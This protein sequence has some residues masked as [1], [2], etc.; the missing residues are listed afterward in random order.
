MALTKARLSALVMMTT[1][2][3]FCIGAR[4][5][6]DGSGLLL[7]LAGTALV[8]SSAAVLNQVAE[9]ETDSL[10]ERTRNR[11]IPA[12]RIRVRT[13]LILGIVLGI[14]GFL[15]LSLAVNFEAALLGMASL[16]IYVLAYT[17]MKRR[18]ASC[19]FVGAIAGALPPVI[20]WVAAGRGLD[21]GA[22]ILFGILFLWQMPHFLAIAWMHRGEYARAG[23]VMLRRKDR[24]GVRAALNG[25]LFSLALF[26]WTTLPVPFGM[27]GPWYLVVAVLCSGYL[28]RCSMLFLRDRSRAS[29]K[30]LFLASILHL[31]LVLGAMLWAKQ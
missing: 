20:G 4:N 2:T 26:V 29:A 11:P 17:P 13:A 7:T 8:A 12:G 25:V 9:R 6:I 22:L 27:T 31:P 3:G 18:S 5:G 24:G 10:M 15:E 14:A 28:T 23:L 30:R 21:S 1:F 16:L 19:T